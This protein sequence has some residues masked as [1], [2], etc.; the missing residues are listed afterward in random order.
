M[1][2]L[3]DADELREAARESI[4]SIAARPG[5]RKLCQA[6]ALS[7]GFS[8]QIAVCSSA[9]ASTALQLWLPDE[10][11]AERD[12]TLSTERISPYPLDWRL[13]RPA[14]VG[15]DELVELV[16][17]GLVGPQ[18]HADLVFLD[19]ARAR[20]DEADA[21]RLLF[22]R[23]NER[24]NLIARDLRAALTL[25]LPPGLEVEFARAAPDFWSIRSV[26]VRDFDRAEA[27]AREV[28]A[29]SSGT[30]ILHHRDRRE[31]TRPERLFNGRM[32]E[33]EKAIKELPFQLREVIL[34][35]LANYSI[36]E[37]AS[38]LGFSRG[39][40]KSRNARAIQLLQTA[41]G[42]RA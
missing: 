12:E 6:L 24:R 31:A 39:T 19:A 11:A 15:V 27:E 21:W 26:A 35:Y 4:N 3:P 20:E 7:E 29:F 9:R 13:P 5:P 40:V 8:F 14:F 37:I 22:E 25:I 28:T 34:L 42:D 17:G 41:L 38:A 10:V 30:E 16:M 33:L 18:P 2:E 32:I 1:I 36:D 23:L